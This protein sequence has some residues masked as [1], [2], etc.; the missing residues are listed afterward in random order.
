MSEYLTDGIGHARFWPLRHQ[1]CGGRS[2]VDYH[3]VWTVSIDDLVT[4]RS[5]DCPRFRTTVDAFR[6]AFARY[7]P[8]TKQMVRIDVVDLHG[9]FTHLERRALRDIGVESDLIDNDTPPDDIDADGLVFSGGPDIDEIGRVGEYLDL[10]IPVLGICLGMQVLAR[11]LG[12]SVGAG[13][14][15]GYADITVE[16]LDDTDPVVGPLHP[17][18]QVW[19]S[20]ADE[21]KA[22]PEGFTV[23]ARSDVCAIEAMSDTTRDFYGVQWHPEVAHTAEG[24][25]VLEG[26]A[27]RCE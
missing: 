17:E 7:W 25:V 22:V 23:T 14:Y 9:Q 8:T 2:L 19:A 12:G 11:E 26:F 24:E 10:D 18:T 27:G 15:G 1:S 16:I 6:E 13:D 21:V 4:C 20:H 5:R 3:R